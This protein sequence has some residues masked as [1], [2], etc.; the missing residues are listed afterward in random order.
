[1]IARRLGMTHFSDAANQLS[2]FGEIPLG[3][4]PFCGA[5]T[6]NNFS[7]ATKRCGLVCH[8]PRPGKFQSM[9]AE[10]NLCRR[11]HRTLSL[12]HK[13][14]YDRD[15]LRKP[16]SRGGLVWTLHQARAD[17]SVIRDINLLHTVLALVQFVELPLGRVAMQSRHAFASQRRPLSREK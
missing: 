10:S 12:R 2:K 13:S 6:E 16:R 7:G 11:D 15:C 4:H 3:E 5:Q 14:P 17:V 1:M 9:T 8:H